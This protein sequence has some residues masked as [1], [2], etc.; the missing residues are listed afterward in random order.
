MIVVTL[1]ETHSNFNFCDVETRRKFERELSRSSKLGRRLHAL[2]TR[3]GEIAV[4]LL[5]HSACWKTDV[6]LGEKL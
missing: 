3:S 5:F 1:N 6:L 4:L 2:S